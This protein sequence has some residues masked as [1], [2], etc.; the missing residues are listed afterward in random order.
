[1]NLCRFFYCLLISVYIIG[2]TPTHVYACPKPGLGFFLKSSWSLL[3]SLIK[4]EMCLFV[5]LILVEL[6]NINVSFLYIMKIVLV[7][8]MPNNIY[9]VSKM[10][11]TKSYPVCFLTLSGKGGSSNSESFTTCSEMKT[12]IS[13]CELY[14]CPE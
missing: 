13:Y 8:T 9:L 1:M 11:K 6:L 2:L 4:G 10:T 7:M 14:Y 5:F 3:C 12:D